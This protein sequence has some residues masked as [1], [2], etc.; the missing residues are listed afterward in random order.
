[1]SLPLLATKFQIPFTGTKVI[2]RPSLLLRLDES[3]DKNAPLILVCA[4]A[5][6]GKTTII[7]EWL[8]R[9]LASSG[10]AMP[11]RPLYTAWVTLERNDDDLTRFLKYFIAA[12]QRF[13]PGFG[14]GVLKL[15]QTHK[16]SPIHV[17]ATLL[18]NE[19]S[20]IPGRFLMVLDDFHSLSA[21]SVQK[22]SAFL[23]DHQPAHLILVLITRQDPPL[24]LARLRA[25]NQ[26]VEL[27]QTD[28]C[29]TLDEAVEFTNQVMD[30]AL[31]EEQI[32]L[33][34]K[35]TEGWITGL[36]LAA[37]SMRHRKDRVAFLDAF[38]GGHE[39][40]ADYLTEEVLS[41]LPETV[42]GFLL[43]TSILE[44][45]SASLCEAV[46]GQTNGQVI[47]DQLMNS[48]LFILSLDSQKTWYR[49]HILFAD[50]LRKRLESNWGEKVSELH[51]RASR[52]FEQ[53]SMF[54]LAIEHALAGKDTERAARLIELIA[55]KLLMHGE[56]SI[57]LRWL[58]VLPEEMVLTRPRLGSLF[59]FTM[60]LCGHSIQRVM[61]LVQKMS[62]SGQV[63][64]FQ[65][66]MSMLQAL[67]ATLHGEG[68]RSIQL[69]EQ[70]LQ[71]LPEE[72][73]FF[74]SIA[75][76]TLGMGYTLIG[77][78]PAATRAFELVV[79][80]SR[81]SD[82]VMMTIAALTNLAGL[83]F[84]RGQLRVA[85]ITCQQVLDLSSQRI[86]KQTPMVG[87]T[88]LNLGEMLREQGDLE[89]ALQYLFASAEMMEF[90]AEVGLPLAWLSIARI[91][92]NQRDWQAAQFY[93][94]KAR[95]TAQSSRSTQM[96]DRLVAVMQAR[97][98]IAHGELEPV[99]HWA[100][101]C[102]FLDQSPAELIKQ[103]GRNAEINEL[104]Q[105]EYLTLIRLTLAQ[106]QPER[107]LVL[108]SPLQELI[109]KRGYQRRIIEILVL[110]AL[111]LQQK[112][113][114]DQAL[115][116]LGN[117]L[118]LAEPE[119]YQRIILDEGEPIA[120]LLYQAVAQK[121]VPQYAGKLLAVFS[122]E[123]QNVTDTRI[124]MSGEMIEPLS[125]REL[126]VLRLIAEG[127]SNREIAQRLVISLS[128]VKGHT[129]NI[130]GKLGVKNRTQATARSRSLG[131]LAP[132]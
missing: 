14:E 25:R 66:E 101:G 37:L 97:Y 98:W 78:I 103:A 5:G 3:L 20:E 29:F 111:A 106:H 57:L 90:F 127:L 13:R 119:G 1:M 55:E 33:L 35:R 27:R 79:E 63:S 85:I 80:I 64:E 50:L 123:N 44:R 110:K 114:I 92:M 31:T 53:S 2:P 39:F 105:G 118:F 71:Q 112:G 117:A 88:L 45:L 120:K 96:D 70:A 4:P 116:A 36:Q 93:I 74:R 82:N 40:I 104:F 68:V 62:D 56:A 61:T 21:E 76:D 73:P 121:I 122:A 77:D 10:Q 28:L 19:L 132:D 94:D 34:E 54:D 46:T 95:L 89:S 17:L 113:V 47:L 52:W 15:L 99:L 75:A 67:L 9:I 100:R 128:T 125:Q 81:Q 69:S 59:G 48:N 43:Q 22:L 32:E 130:F 91:K 108:I 38:S 26:L 126:E 124:S 49:Y 30:L 115:Q 42:Q 84:V 41:S 6:Y 86:G 16:P 72:H 65:G 7:S 11:A 8:Q 102:G 109:E 107:A 58:E 24:P 87:K 23:V 83:H 18:V 60:I 51:C 12:I 131:I 129:T